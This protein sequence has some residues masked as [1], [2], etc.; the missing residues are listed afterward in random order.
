LH[1]ELQQVMPYL[2]R[3]LGQDGEGK[4]VL[5]FEENATT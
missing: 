4:F 5:E 1:A 2:A 3:V